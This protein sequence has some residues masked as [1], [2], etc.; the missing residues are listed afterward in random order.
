MPKFTIT[1][2]SVREADAD[3]LAVPVYTDLTPGPGVKDVEKALGTTV[4]V[5]AEEVPVGAN[6]AKRFTG[7]LGETILVATMG[8]LPATQVLF[9]GLGDKR[10]ADTDVARKAGATVARRAGGG[11]S[12]ATTIPQGTKGGPEATV[13]A[14]AEGF[15]LGSYRYLTY[16]AQKERPNRIES[17]ALIGTAKWNGKAIKK[18]I[19]RAEAVADGT[20]IAR[21]VTNMPAGDLTPERFVTEARAVAKDGLKITVLDEKKLQDGGFGGLLGVGAGGRTPPRLIQLR[22]EP[23]G[24]K[25]TIALVG[26]GITFDSGGINLKTASLDWMKM[27][28]GGGGA[29]LGAMAAIAKLKPKVRVHGYIATAE[30]MPDAA[31]LHPGDVITIYG[32]KTVEI[33]NTDAEGRLVMADAIGYA[34]EKGADVVLDIATLTG[35]A[36]IAVGV[37]VIAVLGEPRSEVAK[38]LKAAERGGELAWELPLVQQYRKAL[39]SDI[40][41][42]N[43][44][45]TKPVSGG[46]ITAALFLKEFVGDTPWVHIDIAGPAKADEDDFERP[47]WATGAG[48]RTLVQYVLNQ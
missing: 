39:D 41:D 31:A 4:A 45:A 3:V 11:T 22:W 47:K 18:A 25:K 8:K 44:I 48:V 30:N 13:G 20:N 2:T 1:E 14:F 35:A 38:V 9:V 46:A 36:V 16:K 43:N 5:L 29:V 42:L 10:D 37:K 7:G 26:K 28:M 27:D 21:D 15:L 24:A 40:A 32:G 17:V 23:P 12:L 33:G 34:K 19:A 6:P